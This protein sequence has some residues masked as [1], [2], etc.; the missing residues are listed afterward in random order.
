MLNNY[1][2]ILED[3]V[4]RQFNEIEISLISFDIFSKKRMEI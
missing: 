1:R 2:K 3:F 4:L